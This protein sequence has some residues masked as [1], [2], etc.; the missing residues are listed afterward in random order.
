MNCDVK[1]NRGRCYLFQYT[2]FGCDKNANHKTRSTFF[3]TLQLP[4]SRE[5]VES[6]EFV[7]STSKGPQ[8]CF[9]KCF[10]GA[11]HLNR[12]LVWAALCSDFFYSDMKLD[13]KFLYSCGPAPSPNLRKPMVRRSVKDR[14]PLGMPKMDRLDVYGNSLFGLGTDVGLLHLHCAVT[15]TEE[16]EQSQSPRAGQLAKDTLKLLTTEK[17]TDCT[18]MCDGVEF[19]CH[20]LI[21]SARSPVFDKMFTIDLKEQKTSE[22]K[23]YDLDPETIKEMLRY[24]YSD[25]I[26]ES[27]GKIEDLLYAADKYD[28]VGLKMIC[29]SVLTKQ[30]S[31]GTAADLAMLAEFF[32]L[33]SLR[34]K[35]VNFIAKNNQEF[36]KQEGW[37]KKTSSSPH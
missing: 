10:H 33:S 15:I 20:K 21:L 6:E 11:A 7:V 28:V 18:I 5:G 1:V 24:I 32:R 17:L 2:F 37:E 35:A 19:K 26:N 8:K 23:I 16:I 3:V 22:V 27:S 36:V 4:L 9:L 34:T 12:V 31:I 25:E 14:L 13:A 30:L 29:E